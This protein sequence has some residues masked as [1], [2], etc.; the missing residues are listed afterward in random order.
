MDAARLAVR[1]AAFDTV[2]SSLAV[3]TFPDPVSALRDTARVCRPDGRLLLLEHGLSDRAWLAHRQRRRDAAHA[4][5][6]GCHVNRDPL[7]REA[8]L[9]VQQVRRVLFGTHYL[10]EALPAG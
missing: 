4:R 5:T 1:D 8:G 10:I 6:L 9:R 3:C 2:V 7:A